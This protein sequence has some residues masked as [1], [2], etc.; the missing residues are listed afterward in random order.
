[1]VRGLNGAGAL[2]L[3][4]FNLLFLNPLWH[5]AE[6]LGTAPLFNWLLP[7][8]GVPAVIMALLA[9]VSL[10]ADGSERTATM[11]GSYAAAGLAFAMS[12]LGLEVMHL[13]R[14]ASFVGALDFREAALIGLLWLALAYGLLLKAE[15]IGRT[16]AVVSASAGAFMLGVMSLLIL[17]PLWAATPVGDLLVLNWLLVAY[18]VPALLLCGALYLGKNA[19][20]RSEN[21]R[22]S[23]TLLALVYLL[24]W[25]SLE[26]R[27]VFH[28]SVLAGKIT[29]PEWYSYSALW[30]LSGFALLAFGVWKSSRLLRQL[31]LG[32]VLVTVAKIFLSDMSALTG[33]WR[34]FSFM[35]LGLALMGV[36]YLYQRFV[37]RSEQAG[38]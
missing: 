9:H 38:R 15:G 2:T 36:G 33:L 26:V 32:L 8:Y 19:G 17:N 11:V 22:T 27:H 25:T 21:S 4:A 23:G 6:E 18:G 37:I 3:V 31:A 28:G 1:M 14:G 13:M 24:V 34:A 7:A 29:Q 12:F 5:S 30:L 35:G 20:L 10:K 16:L